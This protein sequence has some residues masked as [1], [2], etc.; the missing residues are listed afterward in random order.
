MDR[1]VFRDHLLRASER[2]REFA[3][4]FVVDSLPSTYA[5][6]G[7]VELFSRVTSSLSCF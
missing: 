2:C 6:L 3:T 5:F 4:Q 1:E 7:H